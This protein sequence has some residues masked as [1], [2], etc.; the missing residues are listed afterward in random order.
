MGYL[1]R[2]KPKNVVPKM[3][4]RLRLAHDSHVVAYRK[5]KLL[6]AHEMR[7]KRL[8]EFWSNEADVLGAR[9]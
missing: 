5:R 2:K 8:V 4:P 3:R 6:T 1:T 9:E 7:V